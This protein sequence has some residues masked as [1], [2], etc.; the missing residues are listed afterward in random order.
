MKNAFRPFCIMVLGSALCVP[1]SASTKAQILQ[2]TCQADD[3]LDAAKAANDDSHL[4]ST[5]PQGSAFCMGFIMGWAQT[6]SGMATFE[7]N[8]DATWFSLPN[9]F[10]VQQGKKVFLQYVADHPERLD[11]PAASVLKMALSEKNMLQKH[12][13]PLGK[14]CGTEVIPPPSKK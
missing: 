5:D 12:F 9:D 2:E 14:D 7:A 3:R 13:V 10:N 11:Q 6:I 1:A 8:A 4:K